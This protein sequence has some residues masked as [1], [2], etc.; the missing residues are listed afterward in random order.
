MNDTDEYDYA[1]I[2]SGFGGAVAALRLT[3]K[4]Y[5][6]CIVEQGKRWVAEDFPK[7][8]W[9]NRKYYWY[10]KLKC[11]GLFNLKLLKHVLV[12]RGIG[13]GG[14]SL[15]YGNTLITPGNTFFD[16]PIMQYV[17]QG[18]DLNAYYQQ[19]K[20]MMGVAT[21]PQLFDSDFHL[22]DAAI[23][24]YPGATF[25]A[26]PNGI[27]FGNQELVDPYFNGNGPKR[28]GCVFCGGCYLGCRYNAKNTL[29]KNYLYFAEKKGCK[30][31]PETKVIAIIP[32]S[33]HGD[34]GYILQTE[35]TISSPK[36][37]KNIKCKGLV[38]AAGVLGS[39]ELLLRSQSKGYL[40]HISSQLGAHV[41]TNNENVVA[42][43]TREKQ[44]RFDRGTAASSS[45]FL[46]EHT[47][48]QLNR[49]SDGADAIANLTTLMVDGYSRWGRILKLLGKTVSHPR[50]FLHALNPRGFTR[51]TMLLVVMQ[52]FESEITLKLGR[53]W[54]WPFAKML[55]STS[56]R[57][58]PSPAYIPEANNF[59]RHL[60]AEI[61]GIPLNSVPEIFLNTPTTSHILGG[62]VIGRDTKEGVVDRKQQVFG[63][64]NFYICDGS[65]IPANLGVNPALSILALSEHAMSYIEIKS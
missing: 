36:S 12:I 55:I 46:N 16:T 41:R 30:I 5:R 11:H 32:L 24:N 7:T 48:I 34:S 61:D 15:V 31:I 21:N 2:G 50:D 4:G 19:A 63:Y 65:I 51:Q 54:F 39:I 37:I 45:V 20:E 3:E 10:P 35:P 49:Y 62:C 28:S 22:R 9:E 57:N 42:V 59:A 27:Y 44:A 40:P 26:S 8:N 23:K 60:A 43:R 1:I 38:L 53:R 25:M 13:V 18:K 17:A 29:D 52:D 56:N 33:E 14:G 58:K 47:Q 64:K 6:V